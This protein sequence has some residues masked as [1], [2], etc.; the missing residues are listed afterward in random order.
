M[1]KEPPKST[2][3][4]KP[5]SKQSDA[6]QMLLADHKLVRK[7][8]DQFRAASADEKTYL[9]DRLCT[10]LTI[11][12]TL[13]EELFYPA[14]RSKLKPADVLESIESSAK[15]NGLD[16][17]ETGEEEE[18]DLE[19]EGVNGMKLQAYEERDDE[20]V[21]VQAYEEHQ[22]VGELIAQLKT[23][24]PQG[25]DYQELFTELEDAVL[26]HIAREEDL[27]LPVAE[28]LLDVQTLGAAMQRLRDDL[29][30]SLAA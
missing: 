8:F 6:V 23:L 16:M 20:E 28:A 1:A 25:S 29:S 5:S 22:T 26:E 2:R 24:D 19:A 13:E 30:S 14:V 7:L 15:E 12:S 18:P 3:S 17:S 11:H 9:A 27:I 4:T 21:I 10:E